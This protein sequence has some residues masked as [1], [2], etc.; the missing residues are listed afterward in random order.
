MKISQMTESKYLKGGDVQPAKLLTFRGFKK[1]NVAKKDEPAEFRWIAYFDGQEKGLVLNKTNLSRAARAMGSE[2]TDDWIGKQIVAFFDE[3]VEYQGRP[4]GGIRLRAPKLPSQRIAEA[5]P[6]QTDQ[7]A[8]L[9]NFDEPTNQGSLSRADQA[10]AL[11]GRKPHPV[12]VEEE[13]FPP[14][15]EEEADFEDDIPF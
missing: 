11:I 14:P 2:D 3:N 12:Q 7:R 13:E 8:P 10:R 4:V 6:V 9:R 15:R 5:T 1:E